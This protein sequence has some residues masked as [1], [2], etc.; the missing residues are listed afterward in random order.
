[1]AVRAA[2]AAV[3]LAGLGAS[4][5]APAVAQ[6]T[7]PAY[8]VTDLGTL[9]GTISRATDVNA[10]GQVVGSS[11]TAPGQV[12]GQPG[13]HAFL[14]DGRSMLDLGTPGGGPASL[15]TGLNDAGRVAIVSDTA[16]GERHSFLWGRGASTDLGTLGGTI[17]EAVRVGPAGQVVGGATTV[18]GQRFDQAGTHAFL[19]ERG[20]MR[21][22]GTY[23]GGPMS[24]AL[25]VNAAGQVVGIART[26][27]GDLRATLWE[28]GTMTDLGTLPGFTASRALRINEAGQ[29]AGWAENAGGPITGPSRAYLF[30]G[31]AMTDLGT[32]GGTNSFAYGL[33]NRGQVVGISTTAPGQVPMEAGTH[34][35]LWERGRMTDLNELLAPGSGWELTFAFGINDAG[36]IAGSGLVDGREHAFLLTPSGAAGTVPPRSLP[37]T[38]S[39]PPTA[40]WAFA[41]AVLAGLG[42]R[43][44]ARRRRWGVAGGGRDV[45]ERLQGEEHSAGLPARWGGRAA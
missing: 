14:W 29:V 4:G 11:T 32:L 1:M 44:R 15:S 45:P 19:W 17:V 20:A 23:P 24:R 16:N 26:A 7:R 38:G 35:F 39:G 9:G 5:G 40:W 21:D 31:G 6:G 13:T 8:A 43:E 42:A 28:R 34:A 30:G 36:Q 25:G 18:P 33:N 22:L 2:V 12:R 37:R 3:A 41:G 27:G 10:T